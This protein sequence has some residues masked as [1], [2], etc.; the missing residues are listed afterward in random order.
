MS[1]A[2]SVIW[3]IFYPIPVRYDGFKGVDM[4]AIYETLGDILT[5]LFLAKIDPRVPCSIVEK[6]GAD[7]F[8]LVEI[9]VA[10]EERFGIDIPDDDIVHFERT[11][12]IV[13][14]VARRLAEI[15]E[16]IKGKE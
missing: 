13:E 9:M 1:G 14:Y 7:R 10:L 6:Y 4:D 11:E 16:W 5:G 2:L 8:D 12:S 15:E 3:V